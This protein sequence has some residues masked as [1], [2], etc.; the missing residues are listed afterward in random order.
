MKGRKKLNVEKGTSNDV[1]CIACKYFFYKKKINMYCNVKCLITVKCKC[2]IQI[3]ILIIQ[4]IK[5]QFLPTYFTY[6]LVQNFGVLPHVSLNYNPLRR[7]NTKDYGKRELCTMHLIFVTYF[8]SVSSI[9]K[10][11]FRC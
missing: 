3:F 9:S 11:K 5:L 10:R 2:N 1:K 6:L 7:L 4:V 8:I